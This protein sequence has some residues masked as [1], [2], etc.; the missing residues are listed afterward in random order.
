M[1]TNGA[2]CPAEGLSAFALEADDM[3]ILLRDVTPRSL[4]AVDEL[5]RGTAP[6]EGA[7]IVGA[8]LE[9]LDKRG[10]PSLFATHLQDELCALPLCLEQTHFKVLRVEEAFRESR[11]DSPMSQDLRYVY[12]LDD[13]ICEDSFSLATALYHDVPKKVVDRAAE[14]RRSRPADNATQIARVATAASAKEDFENSHTAAD[15]EKAISIVSCLSPAINQADVIT[16]EPHFDPPPRLGAGVACLYLLEIH[17]GS[18]SGMPS[19]YIGETENLADRL[20][21]HRQRFGAEG[22]RM[23]VFPL[24]RG[25]RSEARNCEARGIVELQRSGFSLHN[26]AA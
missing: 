2:D 10:C 5:G 19:F 12:R 22:V 16:L 24:S 1:R 14:L 23:V 17:E 3:R 7:A 11:D 9:E 20:K 15:L 18:F 6:R 4:A 25:G 21:A 26:V 13:G 8:V